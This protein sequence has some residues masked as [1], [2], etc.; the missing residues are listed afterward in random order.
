MGGRFSFGRLPL[1]FRWVSEEPPPLRRSSEYGRNGALY[2]ERTLPP[3]VERLRKL[4]VL[5]LFAWVLIVALLRTFTSKA[6]ACCW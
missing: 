6:T 2:I 3:A 4:G 5:A 1:C